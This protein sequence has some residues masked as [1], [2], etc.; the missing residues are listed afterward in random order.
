[1]E[2]DRRYELKDPQGGSL[3]IRAGDA[4]RIRRPREGEQ[5]F[6]ARFLWVEPDGSVTVYGGRGY[7]PAKRWDKQSGRGEY[8]T[9]RAAS[10]HRMSQAHVARRRKQ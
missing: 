7:D 2:D 10:V 9:L 6:R 4:V 1:M 5:G 3:M 8:R